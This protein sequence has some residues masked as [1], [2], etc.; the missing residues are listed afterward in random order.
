MPGGGGRGP[1]LFGSV[2]A[3]LCFFRFGVYFDRHWAKSFL[4]RD[5][6]NCDILIKWIPPTLEALTNKHNSDFLP[7]CA[8]SSPADSGLG[9]VMGSGHLGFGKY[10]VSRG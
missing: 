3:Q 1:A 8:G 10:G 2:N 9:H 5:V 6:I 4:P 7:P